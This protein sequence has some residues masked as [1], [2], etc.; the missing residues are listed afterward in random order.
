M[1]SL[2]LAVLV[3]SAA[4]LSAQ[5]PSDPGKPFQLPPA[6]SGQSPKFKLQM[7]MWGVKPPTIIVQ[8]PQTPAINSQIDQAMVIH[9]PDGLFV[10]QP[11]RPAGPQNLYPGLKILPTETAS[12]G[13]L[14]TLWPNAK[15]IPIP[16]TWP[17]AKVI[18][19]PRDT[20]GF[21]TLPVHAF[22]APARR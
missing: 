16:I 18:P 14:P 11:A 17:H 9:P 22:T 6:L 1:K 13:P 5:A 4:S 2:A 12:L 10:Q 21:T 20:S 3:A 19:I 8:Q 7:P 15:V